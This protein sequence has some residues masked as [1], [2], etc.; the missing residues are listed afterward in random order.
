MF[1]YVV[2]GEV[3]AHGGASHKEIQKWAKEVVAHLKSID[4]KNPARLMV[5]RFGQRNRLYFVQNFD[6][7][8]HLEEFQ[9]KLAADKKYNDLMNQR[10]LVHSSVKDKVL[11]MLD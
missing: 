7:L 10:K 4:A 6:S 8:K 2:Q 3:G 11:M 5:E 1:T 9:N